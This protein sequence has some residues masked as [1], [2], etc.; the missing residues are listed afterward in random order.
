MKLKT[1]LATAL[2]CL[3][4]TVASAQAIASGG[5]G[6]NKINNAQINDEEY[7]NLVT[8]LQSSCAIVITDPSLL[9]MVE[10]KK[11]EINKEIEQNYTS[12]PGYYDLYGLD[13]LQ[14]FIEKLEVQQGDCNLDGTVTASDLTK[15]MIIINANNNDFHGDVNGNGN[16]EASDITK[17]L[18]LINK[19]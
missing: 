18:I 12:N 16:V 10:A 11:V 13:A 9:S 3:S 1:L 14:E 8:S 4:A 5:N 6:V 7:A 2:V 19:K 15:L 17:L